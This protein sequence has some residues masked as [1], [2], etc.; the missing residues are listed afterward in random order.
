MSEIHYVVIGELQ[1][2]FISRC[3]AFLAWFL[4][5]EK[6]NSLYFVMHILNSLQTFGLKIENLGTKNK[7][8][9]NNINTELISLIRNVLETKEKHISRIQMLLTDLIICHRQRS[10]DLLRRSRILEIEKA[11]ACITICHAHISES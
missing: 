9:T 7:H 5:L 2:H 4:F 1:S 3:W 10:V 6:Q 8:S 11:L